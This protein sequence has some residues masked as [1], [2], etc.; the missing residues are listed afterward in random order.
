MTHLPKIPPA[1]HQAEAE[2]LCANRE[3]GAAP[4]APTEGATRIVEDKSEQ[5][6][7]ADF[8]DLF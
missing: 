6:I 5:G 8:W 4:T 7:L 2:R 3:A 1:P